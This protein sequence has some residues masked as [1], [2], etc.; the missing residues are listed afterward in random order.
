[1]SVTYTTAA[2][3]DRHRDERTVRFWLPDPLLIATSCLAVLALTLAYVGR[4]RAFDDAER[5]R[6]VVNLNTALDADALEPAL[7]N[8][9]SHAPDRRFAATELFR[10]MSSA[11]GERRELT[12]VGAISRATVS[13]ASIHAARS[14]QSFPER[15]RGKPAAADGSIPLF[16]TAQIAQL[17]ASMTVR[18]RDEFRNL[19]WLCGALVVIGFHV[20]AFVQ[21]RRQV[22]VDGLLLPA[23]HLLTAIGFAVLLSRPDPLRDNLLFVRYSETIAVGLGL[24]TALS[25]LDLAAL[26]FMSLVYLPLLLAL[27]LSVVLIVFGSGPGNS[28]AKVNLGPVQPIEG[29]RLLLALF[30][31]GYFGRRWELLREV[32]AESIRDVRLPRWMNLPRAEYVLPVLVGVGAALVFFFFQKDLGPALFLCC[33]FLAVYAVARGRVGMAVTGLAILVSGFYI[34][35]RLQVSA[36]LADRVRMWQS[37]WDNAVPGGDQIT[38]AVWALATGGT[39]GTGLGL[40][41][42]RYLP[43]GHTDL[44][45]AAIGEE[46][47]V[48]GLFAVAALF[49]VLAW[50]GLRMARYAATDYGFFLATSLTLF[51]I[52]PAL[53]MASGV[54][55]ITPLTGVVTPFLSYGGSAMLANFAALGILAAIHADRRR[56][57]D[58]EPFRVPIR[59][60]GAVLTVCTLVLL[61]VAVRVQVVRGDELVVK[62]HL[63]IQADG[64]RRFVYNPRVLDIVRTVPRGTIYDRRGVPLASD[65]QQVV[66]AARPTYLR[67]GIPIDRVCPSRDERCYP[68][69]GSAFH[70]LGDAR[71]AVN[72]SAS[73]TSFVERDS[74]SRLRGFDDHATTVKTVDRAGRPMYTIHRD[75]RELVPVLR[76]RRQ[77]DHPAVVGLRDRPRDVH[78]TLDADLQRRVAAIVT[79]YARKAKGKAAAVVLDADSGAVLASVSY[80]WPAL[81]AAA[82]PP[83]TR[84]DGSDD[85]EGDPEVWLDRARYGAYPPGSAF[86]LVVALAAL[87]DRRADRRYTC[88]RL[89]DGR[90]G[91]YING[92]TRPVRDDV[93]DTHPHGTIGIREGL[94]HSCNAYFAQLAVNLGPEPLVDIASRARISLAAENSA[95]RVRDSLPQIGYGQAQVVASPLRMAS[96]A[97]AIADDG[98][99]RPPAVERDQAKS[100]KPDA[101]VDPADARRLSSYL[102]EAVV[103][104]TGRSLRTQQPPIAGKT[105]TAEVANRDSHGWFVGFAPHGASAPGRKRI[106]FAVIIE[107]AGYGGHTAAPAAGEIVSAAVAAGVINK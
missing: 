82:K 103:S 100:S 102:R 14:L 77:P 90:I 3:R 33:V 62:P 19:V 87:R 32:R 35:H 97:A 47:G 44:I 80:P 11:P 95:A 15:L 64:G 84:A 91:A 93:L 42:S 6:A 101:L 43:A 38:H 30:L 85:V 49:G 89:P 7:A 36:T 66:A 70:V 54:L 56:A 52:L 73:N 78:L 68:L 51:L 107:H 16:T 59:N 92:W 9:F 61:A 55:G 57:N 40:G 98:L 5:G 39:F 75:Y 50:R 48:A 45:L 83:S 23:V 60:L 27:S 81:S 12:N 71:T 13:T 41:D 2:E 94:V 76:H 34:G 26:G 96:V 1:V 29:I 25:L 18:T 88:A 53:I 24:M 67:L 37:P 99:L 79:A 74:D 72:W 69:G 8:V 63:G 58:F 46:L 20:A 17:K 105:G 31:A 10:F 21:R 106:A 104:G 86:K 28:S 65:D 22:R 4:L